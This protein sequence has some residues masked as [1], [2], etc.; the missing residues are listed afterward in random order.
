MREPYEARRRTFSLAERRF[1]RRA[2]GGWRPAFSCGQRCCVFKF[3]LLRRAECRLKV[4]QVV[5]PS[6]RIC[7]RA[8]PLVASQF[9][10]RRE[11]VHCPRHA[12]QARASR[13]PAFRAASAWRS[14]AISCCAICAVPN[15][16]GR[17][18]T[19]SA[20]ACCTAS[21]AVTAQ[22]C[23]VGLILDSG[24]FRLGIAQLAGQIIEPGT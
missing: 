13:P 3:D 2:I 10:I 5:Q 18:A 23:R 9:A 20:F 4:R 19:A 24:N 22:T 16:R 7:V 21:T 1:K 11:A 17:S 15:S 8:N 14:A 12:R 6:Q